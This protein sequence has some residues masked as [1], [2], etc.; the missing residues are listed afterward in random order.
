MDNEEKT[1]PGGDLEDSAGAGHDGDSVA[2]ELTRQEAHALVAH[3]LRAP[4]SVIKGYLGI[5][6]RPLDDD[7]RLAALAAAGRAADRLDTMLDDLLAASADQRVFVP[8]RV[9]PADLRVMAQQ[10]ID[11]MV[12]LYDHLVEVVGDDVVIECD[13]RL[14]RQALCNLVSN[15]LKHT[16]ANG[17]VSVRLVDR[18]T[19]VLVVVE[20]DGPGVPP[21]ERERVFEL[22][23][24]LGSHDEMP[25]GLGLGLPVA[26]TIVE[27]HGGSLALTD[28]CDVSGACFEMRLPRK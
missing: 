5:L 13:A 18:D 6:E 27:Q 23:S 17:R 16:P 3:E 7:S 14:I 15:A 2:P 11:E 24:R 8:R 25:E 22:F 21:V 19:E 28:N 10:V 12:P 4:L 9:E 26:R 20:D 1:P